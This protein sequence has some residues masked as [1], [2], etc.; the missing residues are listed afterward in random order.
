MV[1]LAAQESEIEKQKIR[2][3]YEKKK[4]ATIKNVQT[5]EKDIAT[6]RTDTSVTVI[7]EATKALANAVNLLIERNNESDSK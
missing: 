6:I 7:K 1:E 3:E 4:Q 2:N 5:L